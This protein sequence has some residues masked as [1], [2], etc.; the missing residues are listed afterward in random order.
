MWQVLGA[1]GI[2]P[3]LLR[4]LNAAELGGILWEEPGGSES[5]SLVMHGEELG[6]QGVCSRG[7]IYNQSWLR[8]LPLIPGHNRRM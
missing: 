5:S 4:G 1:C 7:P 3:F 8:P 6:R 2:F